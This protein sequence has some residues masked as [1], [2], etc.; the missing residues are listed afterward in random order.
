[1]TGDPAK[2]PG[3]HD[4]TLMLIGSNTVIAA[5]GVHVFGV[6]FTLDLVTTV[7][8]KCFFQLHRVRPSPFE[9]DIKHPREYYCFL[10]QITRIL[11]LVYRRLN[12]CKVHYLRA[13]Q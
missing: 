6:F 1:M 2:I 3:L 12:S 10:F 4:L 11:F 8:A 13:V 5:N 9:S 7:S